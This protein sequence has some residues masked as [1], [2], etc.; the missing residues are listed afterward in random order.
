MRSPAATTGSQLRK[1]AE[2][3][4]VVANAIGDTKEVCARFKALENLVKNHD[5]FL[6]K[7]TELQKAFRRYTRDDKKGCCQP[8][9]GR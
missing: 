8:F 9:R 3:R 6:D 4:E 1:H 7:L 5:T 2:T